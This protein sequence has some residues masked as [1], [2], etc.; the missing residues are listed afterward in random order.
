MALHLHIDAVGGLAGDMFVAALLDLLRCEVDAELMA[1]LRSAG[2][3]ERVAIGAVD[4]NDGVLRGRRFVVDEP[5]APTAGRWLRTATVH[6]HHPHA[7]IQRDI[8]ASAMTAGAKARAADIF[9]RLAVAE[10]YVHG[11]TIDDVAFHEV[12]AQDSIADVCAA[13]ILLDRLCGEMPMTTSCGSLP[14]GSG[15]INT[16][17]GELPVPAPATL[18]LLQGLPM[19]DDGRPGERI[20]PTGAAILA[21]LAPSSRVAGV[22]NG[23]GIGFGTRVLV[24]MSNI[25]RIS[26][27]D[28]GV[29]HA[30]HSDVV[31]VIRFDIDDQSAEDLALGL[32]RLRALPAVL[33]VTTHM[34]IGKKGRLMQC[35]QVLCVESAIAEVV[36]GC[37]NETTTIGVRVERTTRVLLPRH[38]H[39]GDGPRRKTAIRPSGRTT[40]K[41]EADELTGHDAATRAEMKRRW[42]AP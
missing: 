36:D 40:T 14:T 27:F 42:E 41:V 15:M 16:A 5:T 3:H 13:A 25:T 29:G 38:L 31:G 17:H 12:G 6:H 23:V 18:Q 35:V 8:A 2:L 1:H 34:G 22:A 7:A 26:R 11:I 24:G 37:L 21:H 39:Q 19:H 9:H 28:I 33:D 32:D 10:A 30:P 4:H 20:T